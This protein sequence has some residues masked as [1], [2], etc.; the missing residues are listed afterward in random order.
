MIDHT[1][2]NGNIS[3]KAEPKIIRGEKSWQFIYI[4]LGFS[5]SIE[6]TFI[7][8]IPLHLLNFPRNIIFYGVVASI[9]FWLFI[10]NGRFQD[11]MLRMKKSYEDRPQ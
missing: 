5:I 3:D 1:T 7:Q 4:A 8:M 9:T 2:D 6:G 11:R 10:S